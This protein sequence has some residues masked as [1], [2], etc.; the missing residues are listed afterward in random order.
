MLVGAL[1][2]VIYFAPKINLQASMSAIVPVW[3]NLNVE[4]ICLLVWM[5]VTVQNYIDCT[6]EK[7]HT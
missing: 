3:A 6:A 7:I 5:L 4:E 1:I 2:Y